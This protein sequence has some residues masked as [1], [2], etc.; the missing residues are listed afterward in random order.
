[1]DLTIHQECIFCNY[2]VCNLL[3]KKLDH[4]LL[5][6]LEVIGIPHRL[7]VVGAV[8]AGLGGSYD[9]IL[10]VF[11]HLLLHTLITVN[12]TI[13]RVPPA[14]SSSLMILLVPGP[15]L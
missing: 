11:S 7:G 8:P 1:M 13:R 4:L 10:C 6:V 15:N 14:W 3:S 12:L 9:N 5:H 2:N